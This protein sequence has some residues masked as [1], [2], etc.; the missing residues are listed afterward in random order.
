MNKLEFIGAF[1]L[2]VILNSAQAIDLKNGKLK[3][4]DKC[5]S[6]HIAKYGKDGSGVYTKKNLIVKNHAMLVQRVKGCNKN[7]QAGFSSDEIANVIEYLNS[8]FYKFKE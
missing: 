8:T 6:C 7:T 4:D 5:T 3:H 1:G 2:L